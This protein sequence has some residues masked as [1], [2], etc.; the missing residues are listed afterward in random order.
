MALQQKRKKKEEKH[1]TA[2]MSK[3]GQLLNVVFKIDFLCFAAAE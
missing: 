1:C 3:V 2:D